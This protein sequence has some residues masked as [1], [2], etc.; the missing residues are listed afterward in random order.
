MT[1]DENDSTNDSQLPSHPPLQN[2]ISMTK[3]E[4]FAQ[5]EENPE[6]VNLIKPTKIE[7]NPFSCAADE[8][9]GLEECKAAGEEVANFASSAGHEILPIAESLNTSTSEEEE[10]QLPVA[11]IYKQ[12]MVTYRK[13][14]NKLLTFSDQM[15]S[16]NQQ[17]AVEFAE[18]IYKNMRK[19]ELRLKVSPTYLQEVQNP[20]EIKDTSRAFLVEWI[21]DVHRKFR[22][23]PETLYVTVFL[24]DRYLSTK[25]IRKN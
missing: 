24:I 6:E 9:T 7:T 5:G 3:A 22:L 20:K 15:E 10:K 14:L 25:Q 11:E 8:N 21:I 2:R 1:G 17:L 18:D 13:Q 19:E 4:V 16:R 23:V 12:R